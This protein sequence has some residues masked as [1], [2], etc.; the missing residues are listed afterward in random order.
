MGGGGRV[1]DL[2]L[3]IFGIWDLGIGKLE[4]GI[5]NL[6]F[7]IWNLGFQFPNPKSQIPTPHLT[8]KITS[9]TLLQ[10]QSRSQALIEEH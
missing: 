2:G 8:T 1:S 6:E 5:W 4:F 10:T 9:V 7:G 3:G